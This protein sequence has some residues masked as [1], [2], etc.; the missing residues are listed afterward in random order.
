MV[1]IVT[2]SAW[3]IPVEAEAGSKSG[4]D[5]D[6]LDAYISGQ[7]EK[8]GIRG[9]SLGDITVLM[10]VDSVPDYVQGLVKLFWVVGG[11]TQR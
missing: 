2:L 6:A 4:V 1:L 10:L 7:M 8:H 11:R 9:I 5:A 3:T